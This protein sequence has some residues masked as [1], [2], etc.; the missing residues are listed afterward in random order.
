M[1]TTN[2]SIALAVAMNDCQKPDALRRSTDGGPTWSKME[3]LADDGDHTIGNPCPVVDRETSTIWL[4]FCRAAPLR[5]VAT[6]P[7]H[8]PH[9][10][11]ELLG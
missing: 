11:Y 8:L 1:L 6:N 3:I 7:S 10:R 5:C 4:P 2:V 9:E